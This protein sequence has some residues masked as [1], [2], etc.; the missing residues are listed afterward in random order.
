MDKRSIEDEDI[1]ESDEDR[2][3]TVEFSD[4][5]EFDSYID[6][7]NKDYEDIKDEEVEFQNA[8]SISMGDGYEE[9]DNIVDSR[10]VK[11]TIGRNYE[12]DGSC[13]ELMKDMINLI[14]ESEKYVNAIKR[15][16][17]ENRASIEVEY[18]DFAKRFKCIDEDPGKFLEVLSKALTS[19]V[20]IYYP[21]YGL[22]RPTIVGRI[23]NLP[24]VEN[25]RDLRNNHINRFVRVCGIVTRR[26][27]VFSEYLVVY[28]VCMKCK[29]SFGPFYV[30]SSS[31]MSNR[32]DSK[33][34][35]NV[36][37]YN[38]KP[39]TCFECQGGGPFMVDSQETIYKNFQRVTVQ[40]VPG[41]T[42]AGSLPRSKEVILT[43]DL[44][45]S[46]KPGDEVDIT[47]I[48]RNSY[49]LVGNTCNG[50]PVFSTVIECSS[51]V[52]KINKLEMTAEDVREIKLLS[53]NPNITDMLINA[54]APGIYGHKI[55]KTCVL[56]SMVG[57]E[58][59]ERDG[60]RIRGDINVLLVGDPGTAKSQFLRFV[61]QTSHRAVLAN[62]QGASSVGLT[63]CVRK[64]S[65][66]REWVLEGGA[67][68][69]ADNGICC[70]DEFDKMN[71]TDRVAIHEAM[72]QQTITVA[73]AGIVASLHARCGVIAAAN[74][75]RGHYNSA[76]SFGQNINLSDP[77]ISRFDLLCVV[78]DVID[79]VE[80]K[81]LA[82]FILSV[83]SKKEKCIDDKNETVKNYKNTSTA[84]NYISQDIFKKYILYARN[85]VHP[86][87][88]KIDSNKISELYKDLRRESIGTG[89][90]ITIRQ[91]ES[92]IRISEA[93]AKLRLSP[94]VQKE[95]ID[96]AISLTLNSFIN[97]QKY[98]VSKHLHRKFSKYFDENNDELAVYILKRMF[99]EILG[100]LPTHEV[101]KSEFI[102]RCKNSSITITERF[103]T[104]EKFLNSGF[105]LSND[106]ITRIL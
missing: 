26:S 35:G 73:K 52:Q 39:K 68:V 32:N 77:I 19:V 62:G 33:Q 45:D 75:V 69:L 57:G 14:N 36:Y 28:Y 51:I 93:F 95:D 1:V 97:S 9:C 37:S 11:K 3:D 79:A 29:A 25:I 10:L 22:I 86:T 12:T 53:R 80:D 41:R 42:P 67:L 89:V 63:A 44:I 2:R 105:V 16:C 5:I 24:V 4:L 7:E 96:T 71:D 8:G 46:C 94:V 40:D 18:E 72:E 83:K 50:F 47:G 76:I 103:F 58:A 34:N 65:A 92:I 54:V 21:S 59:K 55:E 13:W 100:A 17:I 101:F 74:P 38:N 87:I 84:K 49:S 20:K 48:Y 23:V 82:D 30:N 78:K 102:A 66:M 56:L 15:M 64:D 70:I 104:S 91:V 88:V 60:M 27:G 99:A 61:H 31:S 90:P 85:N 43:H 6:D 98:S 81:N 106:R